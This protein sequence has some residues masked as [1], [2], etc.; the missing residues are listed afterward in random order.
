MDNQGTI[1]EELVPTIDISNF[2]PLA[3]LPVPSSTKKR[4]LNKTGSVQTELYPVL[5]ALHLNSAWVFTKL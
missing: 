1:S 2:R 3:L 4:E 5:F